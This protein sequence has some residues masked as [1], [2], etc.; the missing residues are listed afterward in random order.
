MAINGNGLHYRNGFLI[1]SQVTCRHGFYTHLAGLVA[2]Y[3][4]LPDKESMVWAVRGYRQFAALGT[5]LKRRNGS[6][7]KGCK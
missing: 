6:G 4:L 1:A 3:F 7:M 2:R 5:G